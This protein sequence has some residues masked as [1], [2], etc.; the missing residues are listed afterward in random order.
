MLYPV[1]HRLERLG[2]VKARWEVGR[3]RP[4]A[5]VLPDHARRAGRSSPRSAGSGRRW[6]PRCA[7]SGGPLSCRPLPFNW[8]GRL[9]RLTAGSLSDASYGQR[10]V[11]SKSRSTSG[12]AILSR[13]Q[14]I[15]AV[16]VAELEDH[17]REQIAA[18]TDA[19]LAADEAFLVAV[20]RMG[21]LDAL[22]REFAREHSDRLWKQLVSPS[23]RAQ[24]RRAP[25][26]PDAI[27]AFAL[28]VAAAR[29]DQGAGAVRHSSWTR[30]SAS[31]PAM[32]ASSSCRC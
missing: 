10:R 28:A 6:T 16:D 4:P 3:D 20:K 24:R 14:A 25:A 27:V 1:L 18:L 32:R 9:P 22:S 26:R 8:P 17:L 13:R 29:A 15:H 23:A 2:H 21:D 11:R 19:G 31:T 5:Q 12:G 30:T 7:A